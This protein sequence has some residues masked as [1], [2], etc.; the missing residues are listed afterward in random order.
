MRYPDDKVAIE[1]IIRSSL[2]YGARPIHCEAYNLFWPRVV[3][4]QML[5]AGDFF[6]SF[7]SGRLVE[8]RGDPAGWECTENS[9]KEGILKEHRV[10]FI[11]KDLPQG[12]VS[13]S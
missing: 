12:M 6:I 5:H 3:G 7:A 11:W 4:L 1:T 13:I 8:F 10:P 2:P 9:I